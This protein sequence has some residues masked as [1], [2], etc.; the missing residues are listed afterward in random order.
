MTT[1]VCSSGAGASATGPAN[2]AA[3]ASTVDIWRERTL[4]WIAMPINPLRAGFTA[5]LLALAVALPLTARAA[6]YTDIWWAPCLP[7]ASCDATGHENGWGV[8]LVQNGDVVFATFYVY[9]KAK[10]AI[11]YSSPMFANTSAGYSGTL[12]QTTGSWFGGPWSPSDV[13]ATAVGASTFTPT[14]ATTGTLTYSVNVVGVGNVVVTKNIQRSSFRAIALCG[15]YTGTGLVTRSGCT[16]SSSNNTIAYDIDPTVTQT[17]GG[18]LKID[19]A[20]IA[21]SDVCTMVGVAAQEGQLF[22]VPNATYKC[23]VTTGINTTA[24]LY[25]MKATAQGIE[26]RWTANINGGCR[27]DGRFTALLR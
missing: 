15:S 4:N 2:R 11:W 23:T 6:D 9:D 26:G 22:R 3:G 25:E 24:T 21:G 19:F 7:G 27:E 1:I 13:L 17:G 16:D 20:Y 10:Q 5:G 18:A 8:N 12:Y 14:S